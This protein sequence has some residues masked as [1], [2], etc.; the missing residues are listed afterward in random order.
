M[1]AKIGPLPLQSGAD[2]MMKEQMMPIRLAFMGFRHGHIYALYDLARQHP[3]VEIA[4]CCEEDD[5]TRASLAGTPYAA[6][7]DSYARMLDEVPCDAVAVGEY[8]GKRG[9]VIIAALQRGKHVISDKPI[10]TALE[11]CDTITQ[12]ARA[13]GLAVGCQL[14]LR[15]LP[16]MIGLRHALRE[17]AIG[18]VLAV[19]FN[20]QHPL[21]YQSGRPDWY[22]EAGKH[23][24]AI[25]DIAIHVIDLLPWMTGHRV[26]QINAA[27]GWN[28]RLP[29]APHFQ[30]GAQMMLTL[31]NGAGVLGDVSY[32][33]PDS[34]NYALP[35]Y[36]RFTFWG[37]DG[38]LEGGLNAPLVLC[39][40]GG[41]APEILPLPDPTPGAYLD[42]F[43]K[44]VRGDK[45]GVTLSTA[46]VLAAARMT[47][48]VQ[49]EADTAGAAAPVAVNL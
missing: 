41:S 47:L 22:F 34:F 49:R 30:D 1:L 40:N 28:A 6:T 2:D 3:E 37:A 42:A 4:A 7:H 15:E 24:G 21:K 39:R 9:A 20:G 45:D 5:A 33:A 13:R 26:A 32:F 43:I 23:G 46:E 48:L 35:Q 11:E 8:Y 10:C 17:G 14:D 25:N 38:V 29:Q 18:E 36:W 16:A 44:E 31:A 19:S 27:R 12:L